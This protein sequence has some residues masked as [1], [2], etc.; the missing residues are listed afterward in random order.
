[1]RLSDGKVAR[2]VDDY[3]VMCVVMC[4]ALMRRLMKLG[5]VDRCDCVVV[6]DIELY[7]LFQN[8]RWWTRLD[9]Y[10]I[11]SVE[12]SHTNGVTTKRHADPCTHTHLRFP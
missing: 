11:A 8:E 12:P 4:G 2:H 10:T 1:V 7:S 9:I 6:D 5:S 3:D